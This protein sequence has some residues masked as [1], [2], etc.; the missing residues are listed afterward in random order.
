MSAADAEQ[1][2]LAILGDAGRSNI[3]VKRLG[4]RVMARHGVMLAAFLVQPEHARH[5]VYLNLDLDA[6]PP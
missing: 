1:P 2:A 4:E 5:S 6:P 3:S